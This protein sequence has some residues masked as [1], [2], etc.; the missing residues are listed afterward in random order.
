MEDFKF[1]V[2][3]KEN[4]SWT[5]PSILEVWDDTGTLSPFQY[6]KTGKLNP[7]YVPVENYV[8]QQFTGAR[9]KNKREIYDG[10]ILKVAR[11]H[12]V[13]TEI[14]KGHISVSSVEDGEEIGLIMWMDVSMRWLIS[15]D[16]KRYDDYDDMIGGGY[17]GHHRYE[18]I[19]N[20]FENPD[21]VAYK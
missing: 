13:Q 4:K 18:I 10:D 15:Y 1:R 5:S 11:C 3:D 21:L 12:A 16:Y 14:S 6:I 19:G 2:W 20:S 9:D 7:L 8:I 17:S